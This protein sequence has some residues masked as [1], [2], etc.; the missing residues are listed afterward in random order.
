MPTEVISFGPNQA[1]GDQQIAGAMPIAYNVLIDGAGAI[2]RRPGITQWPDMLS[3]FGLTSALYLAGTVQA[4]G[5]PEVHGISSFAGTVHYTTAPKP[6]VYTI[7]SQHLI[8]GSDGVVTSDPLNFFG[9]GRPTFAT[10]QFRLVAALGEELSTLSGAAGV[11][12]PTATTQIVALSSRLMSNDR[13]STTTYGRILFSGVAQAGNLVWGALNF[14]T[15][16]ARPDAIVALRENSNE[17]YVF[18]ET[19][20]QV[21]TPDPISVLAPGRTVNRGCSAAHSVIRA[22][23]SFAWLDDQKQ[24]VMSDGRTM[25]VISDP[26]AETLDNIDD[27]S[28]CWGFRYNQG[29]FDALVWVLPTD[30]RTF[31]YQKGAGWSQWS[32]WE[33]SLGHGRF[34]GTAHYLF[35]DQSRHLIGLPM[36]GI[37]YLDLSA[38]AD[39]VPTTTGSVSKPIKAEVTTGFQNR[40]TDKRKVCKKLSLTIQPG[41]TSSATTAP[42]L[43]VSWRDDPNAS[44]CEPRRISLGTAGAKGMVKELRTLGIYRSRQ[45]KVEFTDASDFVL[46]RVEETF[47]P[48]GN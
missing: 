24:F 37:G 8:V 7:S 31:V 12:E 42:Q 43:L 6:P 36:E 44:F 16:E 27:V 25:D 47:E 1:S 22:D 14:V 20:L 33:G 2:R 40:G 9:T 19:T 17:L 21:F 39:Y 48:G 41:A 35:P 38:S 3:G 18:G 29:Q 45:W 15:A 30:G 34:P 32:G 23:E 13:T 26:I 46:G 10:T 11:S 28:D 4:T 5:I